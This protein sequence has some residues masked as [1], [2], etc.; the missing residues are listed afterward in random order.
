[1]AGVP[2]FDRNHVLLQAA[3]VF[4]A[5]GYEGTSVS[6]LVAATG[7]LRGSLYGAFGSKAELFR[8]AFA[9]AA[10][11]TPVGEDLDRVIDLLTVALRERAQADRE[12]AR[13]ADRVITRLDGG[14]VTA[15][16]H[17]FQRLI[18]RA[19]MPIPTPAPEENA[20]G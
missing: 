2:K 20:R 12:V 7:L 17:I 10:E 4:A 16:E 18:Q 1:M 13:L 14:E 6:Q 19:G 15:G 3:D 8:T 11:G 9:Y 5:R